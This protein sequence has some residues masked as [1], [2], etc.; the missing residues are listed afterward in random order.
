M[1]TRRQSNDVRLSRRQ[2]NLL[3]HGCFDCVESCGV[4]G[5]QM[6]RVIKHASPVRWLRDL[7]VLHAVAAFCTAANAPSNNGATTATTTTTTAAAAAA[8]AAA[9]TI[10]IDTT[11]VHRLRK[12]W[13]QR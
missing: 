5:D 6:R 2:T 9:V 13:L 7:A 8:L 1:H 4:A 10:I 3:K 12:Q 11:N